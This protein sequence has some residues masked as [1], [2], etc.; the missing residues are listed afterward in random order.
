MNI[1]PRMYARPGW[2]MKNG[3][4][5]TWIEHHPGSRPF[6]WYLSVGV[7][8]FCRR[9]VQ[10]FVPIVREGWL[11][12]HGILHTWHLPAGRRSRNNLID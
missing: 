11:Q 7:P 3:I 10:Q 4:M 1:P 9:L 2:S 5:E 12:V 8:Q 6:G